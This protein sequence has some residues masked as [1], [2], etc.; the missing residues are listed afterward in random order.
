MDLEL[1]LGQSNGLINISY[2]LPFFVHLFLYH[3]SESY[4]I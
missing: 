2:Y 1:Y 3:V 4:T